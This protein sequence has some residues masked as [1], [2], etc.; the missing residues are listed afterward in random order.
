MYFA[1]I[2]KA[3]RG[4]SAS[5]AMHNASFRKLGIAAEY[6][7]I[8]V[9]PGALGCFI[10]I[11][12]FNLRGFNVTIPHKEEIMKHLDAASPEARAIGA[13]NT[14]AVENNLL[15]GYN[16]DASAVYHLAGAAM[17]GAEVLI[18]GAGGAARAAA[19]A[20]IKAEASRIYVVNRT[21]ERAKTLA[22]EFAARFKANI[23]PAAWG[24]PPKANVVI[25]ATPIYD[26]VVADLSEVDTYVDF[27][28]LPTPHT[29][30]LQESRRRGA[31]TIDGVELLVEQG[32]QAEKI[33][34]GVDPD[35]TVMKDA[36]LKFLGL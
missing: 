12:R 25:N 22:E 2:G 30:M 8:D 27:V 18:I 1:V 34:L 24:S 16:T 26:Q 7:A 31:K 5:P 3:V 29:K 10:Q 9:P 19:F 32:A 11:A 15:I 28:Y 20:A 17:R 21:Y 36:V 13:V 23:T 6:W 33:W 4:K 35:R 14:V